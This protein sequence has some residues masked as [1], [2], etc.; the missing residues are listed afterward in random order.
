MRNE[1]HRSCVAPTRAS[2]RASPI[3]RAMFAA[4]RS[5]SIGDEIDKVPKATQ[6]GRLKITQA[7]KF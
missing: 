4:T 7:G 2:T 5:Q 3:A 6:S 1:M